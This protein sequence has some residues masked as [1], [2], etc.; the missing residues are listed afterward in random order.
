MDRSHRE[1]GVG[2]S[3]A[4]LPDLRNKQVNRFLVV[5]I[6]ARELPIGLVHTV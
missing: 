2:F 4:T 6:T 5:A 1:N 3:Q